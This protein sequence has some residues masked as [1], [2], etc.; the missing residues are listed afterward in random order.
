MDENHRLPEWL[1]FHYYMLPLR[2]V[3]LLVDPRSETSPMDVVHRW[4]PYVKI[5]VWNFADLPKYNHGH[6]QQNAVR[7]HRFVQQHFYHECALHMQR[8]ERTWVTFHDVDEYLQP[9]P[10]FFQGSR[11]MLDFF[12]SPPAFN[13]S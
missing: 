1:A 8:L 6:G 5:D 3:V 13:D 11:I 7:K 12:H 4:Q 2:H 10:D 9:N